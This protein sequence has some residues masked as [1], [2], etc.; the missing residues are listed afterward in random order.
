MNICLIL[1]HQNL[2]F[3]TN[4]RNILSVSDGVWLYLVNLYINVLKISR[5]WHFDIV[6]QAAVCGTGIPCLCW[7]ESWCLHISVNSLLMAWANCRRWCKS[8]CG[9]PRCSSWLQLLACHC[10]SGVGCLVTSG[11]LTYCATVLAP[12]FQTEISSNCGL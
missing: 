1:G 7:F 6:G 9:R 8:S 4:F 5:V 10:H 2:L 11:C 3:C 12:I